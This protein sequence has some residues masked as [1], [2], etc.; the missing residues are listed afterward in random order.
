MDNK[1]KKKVNWNDMYDSSSESESDSESSIKT[2]AKA[3]T[4]N[5]VSKKN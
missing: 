1:N 5:G 4:V 2:N 3:N